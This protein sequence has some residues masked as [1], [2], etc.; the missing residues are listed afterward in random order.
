[1]RLAIRG[2][3]ARAA[4]HTKG[5]GRE[6]QGQALVEFAIVF[7]LFWMLLVAFIEFAFV[8]NAVLSVSFVS[9]NAALIAAE[10]ADSATADCS[11]LHSVE[12]G[13]SAPATSK[14]VQKVDIY[15][16]NANGVI[17]SGAITTYTRSSSASISCKVNG[18]AFTVPYNLTANGYPW[19]ARCS[20]RAGCGGAHTGLDTIGVK[21]TYLYTYKTPYGAVLGGTGWTLD[22]ASEM[23]IEP[24][25]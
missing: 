22:R 1:M 2:R 8:F 11:I 4:A 10:A 9:R 19:T 13:F 16:T 6:G 14:Q 17:Q 23:R 20:N 15:W 25:Q 24:Y 12:T 21:V 18:V 5:R 7:P 3:H